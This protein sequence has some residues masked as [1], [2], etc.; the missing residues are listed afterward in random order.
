[1]SKSLDP[2]VSRGPRRRRIAE[3]TA[4]SIFTT[5]PWGTGLGLYL[6][7]RMVPKQRRAWLESRRGRSELRELQVRC[8]CEDAT[9]YIRSSTT[10]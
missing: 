2:A 9:R 3:S 8:S 5:R 1:M 7:R 6:S 10:C 4:R